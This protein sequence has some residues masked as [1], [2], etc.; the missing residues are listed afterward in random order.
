M[1]GKGNPTIITNENEN[2]KSKFQRKII[3]FVIINMYTISIQSRKKNEC[4]TNE[5]QFTKHCSS[6]I[7]FVCSTQTKRI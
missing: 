2:D 3:C 1:S 4:E 5:T 6:I 7:C